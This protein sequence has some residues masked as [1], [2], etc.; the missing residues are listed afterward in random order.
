MPH[1]VYIYVEISDVTELRTL[2]GVK[3]PYCLSEQPV[4]SS[5]V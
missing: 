1:F 4:D 3:R 5:I 2:V